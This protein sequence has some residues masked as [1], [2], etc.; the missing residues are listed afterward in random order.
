[1]NILDKTQMKVKV[2]KTLKIKA[3]HPLS[4]PVK[5]DTSK[6]DGAVNSTVS[7]EEGMLSDAIGGNV[8]ITVLR[9]SDGGSVVFNDAKMVFNR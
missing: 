7:L 9:R 8:A 3:R 1:M 5:L 2:T 6:V 4:P